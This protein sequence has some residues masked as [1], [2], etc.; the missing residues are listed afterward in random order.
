LFQARKARRISTNRREAVLLRSLSATHKFK[1]TW[2]SVLE[3]AW[4]LWG[5]LRSSTTKHFNDTLIYNS[6]TS[7]VSGKVDREEADHSWKCIWSSILEFGLAMEN[8]ASDPT[9]D[10]PTFTEV[11][12]F[13]KQTSQLLTPSQYR[14]SLINNLDAHNLSKEAMN[15]EEFE[16]IEGRLSMCCSKLVAHMERARD[17]RAWLLDYVADNEEGVDLDILREALNESIPNSCPLVLPEELFLDESCRAI[18]DWQTK[19]D[20]L[21]SEVEPNS[22]KNL[23]NH[24]ISS[25]KDFL[26]FA[27]SLANEGRSFGIR[28]RNLVMLEQRIEKAQQLERRITCW[29]RYPEKNTVRSVTTLIR[30]V[31]K[32]SLP[33]ILVQKWMQLAHSLEIW[34]ERS[35]IA[36]RSRIALSEIENLL[37]QAEAMPLNLNEFTEKLVARRRMASRWLIQLEQVAP[38]IP[39]DGM[40]R[41]TWMAQVRLALS[42]EGGNLWDLCSEGVRIP[43]ELPE[44]KLLQMELDAK[45]W[46]SKAEKWIPKSLDSKKGKL[47]ELREHLESAKSLRDRLPSDETNDK[48]LW[49][50]DHEME[51]KAIVQ[52]ADMWFDEVGT[53][54]ICLHL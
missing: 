25:E 16:D 38:G 41:L 10:R 35:H 51:L 32:V 30:E 48:E 12:Q 54:N 13:L 29:Y 43:V 1:E 3:E 31:N 26:A 21:L 22:N 8:A 6:S 20:T 24:I 44:L 45:N 5:D 11:F 34:I 27:I 7:V 40:S 9:Q 18:S 46:S 4:P 52:A 14:R 17:F 23:S 28:F 33:S 39:K 49:I 15:N 37:L 2:R 42:L 50:L 53:L 47:E 19:V 36:I